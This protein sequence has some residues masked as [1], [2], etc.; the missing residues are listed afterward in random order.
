MLIAVL[1]LGLLATACG[2]G[3]DGSADATTATAAPTTSAAPA[4]DAGSGND[5]PDLGDLFASRCPEAAAGV[6]AALSAY[7]TGIAGAFAGQ[8]DEDE[9][10][11]SAAE[12]RR[13]A[14]DAPD[15]LRDDL[16]VIASTLAEFYGAFAEI[17]FDPTSGEPPTPDQ[18]ERLTQLTED[19]DDTAFQEAADNI[20]AWF[21]DN[22]E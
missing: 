11:S 16:D 21:E 10:E 19:F 12:L 1:A 20:T 4:D 7:T 17:G 8:V 13:L 3:D 15:E 18:I 22:C 6:A 9:L 14:E 5:E 2:G